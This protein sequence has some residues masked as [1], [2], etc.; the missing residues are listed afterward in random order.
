MTIHRVSMAEAENT[1]LRER[2]RELV[3]VGRKNI[4]LQ[5]QIDV[6]DKKLLD[7]KENAIDVLRATFESD[8][9]EAWKKAYAKLECQIDA[10]I[11]ENHR[12]CDKVLGKQENKQ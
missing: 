3:D 11:K 9:I 5:A 10:L 8:A 2:L 1:E 6:L 7:C 12:I 4:E